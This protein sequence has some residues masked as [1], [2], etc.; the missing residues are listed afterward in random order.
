MATLLSIAAPVA[1]A[2][3][4]GQIGASATTGRSTAPS[5]PTGVTTTTIPS[6][7]IPR[8]HWRVEHVDS[9]ELGG[10]NNAAENAFDGD[11]HTI[12]RTRWYVDDPEPPHE[13]QLNLAGV[14]EVSG[15]RYLPPQDDSTTGRI[16]QYEFYVSLDGTRWGTPVASG[17]FD[18]APTEKVVTFA[19]SAARHVRFRALSSHNGDTSTAIA[20]LAVMGA[21]VT[22]S[23]TV[24]QPQDHELRTSTDLAVSTNTCLD[25]AR[26]AHW[27]V[28]FVL[29][30]KSTVD[31]HTPPF[32]TTFH[33]LNPAEHV[34]DALLL[35]ARGKPVSGPAA[36]HSVTHVGIGRYYV[37]IGDSITDGFDDDVSEDD[38]SPDG[39]D[40]SH[41]YPPI[42]N[43][44]LTA[45]TGGPH[46]VANVG[47]P[48][49]KS[50]WGVAAI[51][52]VL[53]K[54]P[55]AERFLILMGTNDANLWAPLP[56]GLGLK[57][58][59][60]GYPGSLKAN[61]QKMT[62]AVNAAGKDA[63]LLKPPPALADCGHCDRY[64]DPD[65]GRRNV[66]LIK[67]YN[68]VIDELAGDAANRIT[69][70]PPDLY[71]YFVLHYA[72]EYADVLHPNGIGYQSVARLVC[73]SLTRGAC[74]NASRPA[75]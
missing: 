46:T 17:S 38:V 15:F 71:S 67:P 44:L 14:Y 24:F 57:T 6:P 33:G 73:Q 10:T 28:R 74:A 3:A 59:N 7:T 52:N 5:A 75:K 62:D 32:A 8:T 21:C 48:G 40:R 60:P 56:S 23:I 70:V 25:S 11:S 12:W 36:R 53:A 30:G 37:A 47:V 34:I 19:P 43:G 63:V 55:D 54:Y 16:D 27:S 9:E 58:S 35:D 22:P 69:V 13:I 20:E 50:S 72:Q 51:R 18:D 1:A 65:Q 26:H 68:R 2:L 31:I 4:G 64:P 49:A 45:A 29:D 39:R 41:G 66:E 61:L 42:L